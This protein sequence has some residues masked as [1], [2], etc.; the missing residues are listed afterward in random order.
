MK[1]KYMVYLAFTFI[2]LA[3]VAAIGFAFINNQKIESPVDATVLIP[4][5]DGDD[6]IESPVVAPTD[7]T[8]PL[9]TKYV[10]AASVWPP[11]VTTTTGGKLVCKKQKDIQGNMYCIDAQ[12]E[13]AAGSTYTTYTYKTKVGEQLASTTFTLRTVQCMNYDEPQQSECRN[14]QLSFDVDML[15][16][17]LIH[18]LVK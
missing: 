17:G 9:D 18:Q 13:G 16:D 10:T 8:K 6:M 1:K 2:V 4:I 12:P 3:L 14:E 7:Y 5:D 15:A 11:K